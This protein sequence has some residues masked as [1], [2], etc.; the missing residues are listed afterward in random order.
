MISKVNI[1]LTLRE[2]SLIKKALINYKNKIDHLKTKED[3]GLEV[4]Q[5]ILKEEKLLIY[6]L[7][8]IREE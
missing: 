5:R 1:E 7:E 4:T 3:L 2:F 6:L 8:S